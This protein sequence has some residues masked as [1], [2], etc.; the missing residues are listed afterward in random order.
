[1]AKPPGGKLYRVTVLYELG[2]LVAS[3]VTFTDE[4]VTVN[5]PRDRS[6]KVRIGQ[7]AAYYER[8]YGI[9]VDVVDERGED[10][11]AG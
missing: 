3:D 11:R 1:M 2:G 10:V 9:W 6:V 5:T 7:S 4:Y 8:H